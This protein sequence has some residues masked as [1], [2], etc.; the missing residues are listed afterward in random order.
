ME[1]LQQTTVTQ[2][3]ETTI[4]EKAIDETIENKDPEG[5]ATASQPEKAEKLFTQADLEKIIE[6]RLAREKKKI[7]AEIEEER[8]ESAKLAKL[9][10]REKQK[11][12]L[13][14]REKALLEREKA[15]ERNNLLNETTKQ[16][17]SKNLPIDFAEDLIKEDAES[18]FERINAFEAKWNA[19]LEDAVNARLKGK[20]PT[21]INNPTKGSLTREDIKAMS[22]A[23][24]QA[25]WSEVQAALKN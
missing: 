6:K 9:S 1:N 14:K 2:N 3:E 20:T 24:I 22:A 15:L 10:D 11:L 23:E 12:L 17:S 8:E 18:T 21:L 19:A 16:L 13:D 4:D 5:S 7:A 25:R